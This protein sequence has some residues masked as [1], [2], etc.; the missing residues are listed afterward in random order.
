MAAARASAADVVGRPGPLLRTVGLRSRVAADAVGRLR[1]RKAPGRRGALVHDRASAATRSSRACRRS[2]SARSSRA[3]ALEVLAELQAKEDDRVDRR[4]AREDRPRGAARKAARTWYE[5]YYGTRRRD[6]ALSHPALG[7]LAL[8]GRRGAR[9]RPQASRRCAALDWIDSYGDR[10]GDGFV[11]YERRTERG[12]ENQSWKDSGD[13]Q[14]FHDGTP[15]AAADRAVRGAGLRL[16]R[17]A[18]HRRARARGLARPRA[19]RPARP[20]GG[21]AA[22]AVRRGV[23]GRGARRLLRARARPRQAQGGLALLEH[24]PPPVERHRPAAP[25]STQ[26]STS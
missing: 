16:R 26:S 17:E 25:R 15:R 22:H 9:A 20:R 4:R 19:R 6:A 10:D 3:R 14:R 13:S 1:N 12:L 2:S 24:R 18:A 8:D 11:E 5:R 23:L 21:G 7:G